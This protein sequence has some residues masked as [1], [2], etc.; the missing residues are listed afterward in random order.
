M[1]DSRVQQFVP[2]KKVGT[3]ITQ[4]LIDDTV[5][6]LGE[7]KVILSL[8]DSTHEGGDVA[9]YRDGSNNLALYFDP[10]AGSSGKMLDIYGGVVFQNFLTVGQT[11]LDITKALYV[12]GTGKFTNRIDAPYLLVDTAN[13]GVRTEY[14]VT[15]LTLLIQVNAGTDDHRIKLQVDGND[16]IVAQATGDGAGGV[17]D[18]IALLEQNDMWLAEKNYAG[19]D[20]INLLKVNVDDEI[21][22]G[23]SMNLGTIEGPEDGGA[24]TLVDMPVSATPT[25]GDEMSFTMKIDGD[26]ILKVYAEADSAGGIQN[27]SVRP[28]APIIYDQ[29][30]QTLTGAGAVDITSAITWIVTDGVNALTLTDG[31]EG[32][33]KFIVMKTDVNDGTLT[34][35][36]LGNGTTITF[37][38]VGDSAHLLFTNSAWHFMGGTA[39]LA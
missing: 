33:E 35:T 18:F 8:G 14:N 23:G 26:N 31:A 19:T 7:N 13:A 28:N 3:D 10:D 34:P 9:I 25:A 36:N 4:K 37:D 2:F 5:K 6:L 22:V 38:D 24:I 21:D 30:P 32:Q 29:T 20:Y 11:A 16:I 17:T 12:N 1:G 15:A 27:P 39:T